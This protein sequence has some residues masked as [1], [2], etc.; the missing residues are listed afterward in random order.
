MN[1]NFGWRW[2][3][4]PALLY[5]LKV[6]VATLLGY[7]LAL[8]GTESA[9][10]STMS[11]ALIVGASRGEDVMTST[12]R[13]RGTLAGMVVGIIL[14][15]VPLPPAPAVAVGVGSTA[16][17]CLA[18]GWGVQAARV[19][20]ALC[21]VMILV[22]V[23]DAFQY[24]LVRVGNTLIG[25]ATG[26]AVSYLFLPVRGREVAAQ[27]S[28]ASLAAAS[29]ILTQLART[30]EPIPTDLHVAML[31]RLVELEK[32]IRD[33]RREFGKANETLI[34]G[35]RHVGGVCAGTLT[36]A[37]AHSDLCSDAE[38]ME[39]AV[40]LFSK[41]DQLAKRARATGPAPS[42]EPDLTLVS[43]P[44]IRNT[45]AVDTTALQ[46]LAL[47]LRKIEAALGALGR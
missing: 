15:L 26:L 17:V 13:V 7:F 2:P 33:G 4:R 24:S 38:A 12:N 22:H 36:A 32:A 46:G 6:A 9:V 42:Q 44:Q 47:G 29:N 31:D 23:Q 34:Q 30:R 10:Y 18:F 3:R 41:A 5:C 19:G 37:I 40:P 35:A 8:G 21:A 20:A 43:A 14:T 1:V 45:E 27:A 11:A 16:Y 25:I 28:K 39:A